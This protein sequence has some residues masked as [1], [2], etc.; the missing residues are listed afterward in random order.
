MSVITIFSASYCKA[1]EVAEKVAQKLG[2]RCIGEEAPE[3]A[4]REF[5]VS[6]DKLERAMHGT[7]SMLDK[8]IHEK[9]IDRHVAYLRVAIGELV[10]ADNVVYHGFAGHLL[11]KTIPHILRVCL[12]AKREYRVSLAAEGGAVSKKAALRAIR[13]DDEE[14]KRWTQLLFDVG[15]WD[16]S[17]YDIKIPMH[18]TT[19]EDAVEL[20]CENV[21]KEAVK[22]TERSKKAM[23]DFVF[24]ARV[25]VE[26]VE[27]GHDVDVLSEDGHVTVL[28]KKYTVRLDHLKDELTRIVSAMP[29]VKGMEVRPGPKFKR[30]SIYPGVEFEMP[31]KI[32]LVDDEKEFVQTLSERL[33]MRDLSTAVVY[34]GEQAL[35]Y[36]KSEEPEVMILDLRMPGIDGVEVL[37][38]VKKEHPGVE[39]IILTGHGT[40]KDEQLTRELGAFAYLEKPVEIDKLAKTVKEAYEK[41]HREKAEKQRGND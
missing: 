9:D 8:L 4:S 28:L 34:D 14:R 40:E 19:V 13:K 38:R 33:E 22:T 23:E 3:R 11:P 7:T 27:R 25:H 5:N 16:K 26:L 35:S 41:I 36:L 32:L 37:R 1:D 39:V 17:L 20:I 10:K 12:V 2:Y 18:A 21:Q 24:A 30:P 29:G 15:P 6:R 31:S